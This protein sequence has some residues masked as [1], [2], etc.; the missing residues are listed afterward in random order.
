MVEPTLEPNE[1]LSEQEL[2]DVSGAGESP[3][4]LA[5]HQQPKFS[6]LSKISLNNSRVKKN[7]RKDDRETSFNKDIA[8]W[9][10]SL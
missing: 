9:Y 8:P 10:T 3:A 4:D 7:L 5:E 6:E 2:A 1:E